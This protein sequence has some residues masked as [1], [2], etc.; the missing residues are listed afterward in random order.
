MENRVELYGGITHFIHK[1]SRTFDSSRGGY[2]WRKI[3]GFLGLLTAIASTFYTLSKTMEYAFYI[4]V[5]WQIF[6]LIA[7]GLI[8][9][10]EFIKA[11]TLIKLG[12][13]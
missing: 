6:V 3:S 11:L 10:P 1:V 12:K 7:I 5:S 9:I 8:T 4:I 2:S 13:K